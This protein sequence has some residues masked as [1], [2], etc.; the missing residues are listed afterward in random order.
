M[1]EHQVVAVRVGEE[2]HVADAGVEGLAVEL[3]TLGF[4]FR[5]GGADVLDVKGR[6]G[7]LLRGKLEAHVGR[8]YGSTNYY[9]TFAYQPNSRSS[10]NVAVYDNVAGFGGQV[11]QALAALPTEFTAVRNP[12]SG[13]VG[14]C[15]ATL[16]GNGC[17][18][19]VLG[20]VRSSTFRDRGV[21]ATYAV[22]LGRLSAGIGGGYDRRRF[23]AARGTVLA[24]ANGVVDENYWL[25]AYLNGKIDNRSSFSTNVYANWFQSGIGPDSSAIGATAAYYRHLT[26]HISASA[27]VGID[28]TKED[29]PFDDFWT[30]S[31]L[32]GVRYSF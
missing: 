2:G 15:V 10:I 12:L 22:E 16:E 14:G 31:A 17:L 19:G 25:A 18:S 28:G 20:S 8:R 24:V 26:G 5:A 13:G 6:V 7:V 32:F 27:A 4:Q 11:N 21:M 29:A 30:A 23:I 9:G 3:D 1:V